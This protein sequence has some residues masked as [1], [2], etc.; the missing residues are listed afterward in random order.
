MCC[1]DCWSQMSS[2]L[3]FSLMHLWS[4]KVLYVKNP[5]AH[6]LITKK[7]ENKIIIIIKT[8]YVPANKTYHTD[9]KR[10]VLG[11]IWNHFKVYDMIPSLYLVYVCQNLLKLCHYISNNHRQ[12]LMSQS[13]VISCSFFIVLEFLR[14]SWKG[15]KCLL[16]CM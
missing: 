12:T 9:W 4:R 2:E 14:I 16:S 6:S 8:L 5:L 1:S 7:K 13:S 15:Q 3:F 11:L 10:L